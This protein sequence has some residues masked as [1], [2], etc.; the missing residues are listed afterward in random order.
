M[1]NH[2]NSIRPRERKSIIQSLKAGVTPNAGLQYIQVGRHQEITSL[3][4]D[5]EQIIDG[6]S[7]FR[8]I[9][10]E[11]G[12]GK[13]FFLHLIRSIAL[14]KGLV[15]LHAD[16][17]PEKRLH[18]TKGLARNLYK[19]LLHNI[20]TQTKPN[21]G[22]IK[23]IVEHFII[24]ARKDAD[25]QNTDVQKTIKNKLHSLTKFVGGYDFADVIAAYCEGHETGNE[26]LQ[27]NAVRWLRGEYSTKT[28]AKKAL[29]VR[30]IID[31]ENIYN[32]LKLMA[33]F[34]HEAG[35]K[36]LLVSLDEMVNLYKLNTSKARITNYEQ[37]LHMI[38]D[39]L[40]GNT[41]H[42]GF[43]LGGT[44]EF[45]TDPMKGLYSYEALQTR[46][47]T[48]SFAEK[49]GT[50]DYSG[51]TLRLSS[52]TPEELFHLLEKLR[53]VFAGGDP[54]K[55]LV[56]D[57]AF[58]AFLSHCSKHIGDAYFRTPRNTIKE[59][60]SMLSVLEQ[61]PDIRWEDLIQKTHIDLESNSDMPDIKGPDSDE[62]ALTSFSM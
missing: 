54:N 4:E 19:E 42:I 23:S 58:R 25:T 52:L 18:S 29:G 36:G 8:L 33:M 39:C 43:I 7:T 61:N 6:G 26:Q 47:Q 10:G 20:S 49:T 12:S 5:I 53:H 2:A 30:T 57:E 32:Y 15:T 11:Y 34:V 24:Q 14:K 45:L 9:V 55:Y 51:P 16:L 3:M 62:D 1:D 46:L 48:N 60:V 13:S 27:Q 21:G 44:P 59:F 17:S 56:P 31:D 37:I 28:D 41:R 38:N 35:Y 50:I 22:A 40:Q